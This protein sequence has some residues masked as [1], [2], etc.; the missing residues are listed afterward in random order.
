MSGSN[1]V[2][3]SENIFGPTW[4]SGVYEWTRK[5]ATV[6]QREEKLWHLVNDQSYFKTTDPRCDNLINHTYKTFNYFISMQ[7]LR[8]P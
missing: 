2:T 7:V 3:I 8:K 4:K 1:F 5:E 6:N